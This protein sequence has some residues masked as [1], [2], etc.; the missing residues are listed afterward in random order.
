MKSRVYLLPLILLFSGISCL[1]QEKT[2]QANSLLKTLTGQL[3]VELRHYKGTDLVRREPLLPGID[4]E[5]REHSMGKNGAIQLSIQYVCN[6]ADCNEVSLAA[7]F[8]FNDWST[9]NYVMIPSSVYSGNRFSVLKGGYMPPYP[10]DL[11][12]N[13]NAPISFSDNPRLAIEKGVPSAIELLTTN[14][15]TPALTFYSPEKKRGFIV[16]TP[17]RS[18]HTDTGLFVEENS[19]R[20]QAE[21]TVTTPGVRK[22]RAEFGSFTPSQDRAAT[23]AKGQRLELSLSVY[24]FPANGISDLLETFLKVR[25]TYSPDTAL[26]YLVPGSA[27]LDFTQKR[28]DSFRW[29]KNTFGEMYYPENSFSSFQLGWIGGMMNTFPMLSLNDSTHLEKVGKTIDFVVD[30]LQ[31]KSGFFYGMMNAKNGWVSEREMPESVRN[32][33]PGTKNSLVRKNSDA[34]LWFFKHF[35]LY[36]KL[37]QGHLIKKSWK[38]AAR[39]LADAFISTWKKHHEIGQYVDPETGDVV[40]YNTIGGGIAPAGLA[41]AAACFHQP[42]YLKVAS[43][44]ADFYAKEYVLRYGLTNGSCGDISQD[45]DSESAFG[46]LESLMTLYS[47]TQDEKWL[48]LAQTEAALA[49]TWVASADYQFPAGSDLQVLGARTKGAVWASTQNKHAAPGI[50]TS[51]GDYLFKLFRATGNPLYAELLRDI[52]YAHNEVV[53]LPGRPTVTLR[54]NDKIKGTSVGCS[55]ERIQPSDAEGKGATGNLIYTSN[56]WTETNGML[57][58]MEVPG[59]YLQTD[60]KKLMVF[61]AIQAERVKTSGRSITLKLTNPTRFDARV[62]IFSETSSEARKPL[63]LIAFPDWK[64]VEVGAGKTVL[65]TIPEGLSSEKKRR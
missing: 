6:K 22:L 48:R 62:S 65:V 52:Q 46:F 27:I 47:V 57:M 17:Q 4:V 39:K 23:L 30:H 29:A 49:S 1:A 21:F 53:E 7:S 2:S 44:I 38:D 54:Q 19:D 43:E 12:Y 61:D 34:L 41:R 35:E 5:I 33:H 25:K 36:E 28:V 51:S 42:E 50:C 32:A 24:S 55:M 15:A 14:T 16:L 58:A 13:R 11:F 40:V 10:V 60:T 26:H 63:P 45:A 59:I 37:G 9:A 8:R 64:K 56:G 31:G 3:Q 18:S 20:T